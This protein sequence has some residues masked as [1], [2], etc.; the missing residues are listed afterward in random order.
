MTIQGL[1]QNGYLINNPIILNIT[2]DALIQRLE[3]SF[4]NMSNGKTASLPNIYPDQNNNITLNI[5][6]VIKGLFSEPKHDENYTS[7]APLPLP[8][9]SNRIS[10]SF[11]IY[12]INGT[13]GRATPIVKNFIRGGN[14]NDLTN[15][16]ITANSIL[17]TTEKIPFWSVYP[18]AFYSIDGNYTI[19]K[20][21]AGKT[22]SIFERQN[23]RSCN[24]KYLKFLNSKGGYSYWLFDNF[25]NESSNDHFGIVNNGF[26][27][28]DLGSSYE[29]GFKVSAKVPQRFYPIIRDLIFSNEIYEWVNNSWR[30]IYSDN[31]KLTESG[32][33]AVY[34][35]ELKF[36]DFTNY[37]PS[38][39]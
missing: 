8:F 18:F 33:K 17:K 28:K 5:Q 34:K 25:E 1:E 16:N 12:Y 37:N 7:L 30:R 35:F 38:L 6:Q 23:V 22:D 2:S 19:Y 21:T 9:N 11:S 36:K 26:N 13:S 3:V 39:L 24:G 20:N 27:Q 32:A 15:Q 10:I 4:L 31:N 29:N 14:Y